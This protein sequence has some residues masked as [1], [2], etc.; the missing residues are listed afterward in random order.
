MKY[1]FNK[2]KNIDEEKLKFEQ[3][4]VPN[5]E[6]FQYLRSIVREKRDIKENGINRIKI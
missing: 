4:E 3:H 5:N 2:I 1:S 6:Y